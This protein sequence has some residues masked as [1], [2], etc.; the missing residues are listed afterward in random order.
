[1]TRQTIRESRQ[2][3]AC[4]RESGPEKLYCVRC[5]HRLGTAPE[6]RTLRVEELVAE[7]LAAFSRGVSKRSRNAPLASTLW[8]LLGPLGAHHF[9]LGRPGSGLSI[10]LVV[11]AAIGVLSIPFGFGGSL[12]IPAAVV[13]A[14]A[15]T[16]EWFSLRRL[17]LE[18][19][20]QAEW[21]ARREVQALRDEPALRD[22]QARAEAPV[23]RR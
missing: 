2:C 4:G 3:E 1:M 13:L 14:A 23:R 8:L 20:E 19:H 12:I 9:Y 18:D 11:A 5:G 15:W 21:E 6:S 10:P 17:L 16:V 22:E 7:E